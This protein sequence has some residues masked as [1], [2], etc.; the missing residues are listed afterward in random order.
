LIKKYQ[1]IKVAKIQQAVGLHRSV[2][3]RNTICPASRRFASFGGGIPDL[4]P[5][6]SP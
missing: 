3:K 2:E 4:S 5:A 1:K 6:P